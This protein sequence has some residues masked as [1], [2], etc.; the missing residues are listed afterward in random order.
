MPSIISLGYITVDAGSPVS[1]FTNVGG[2][3]ASK[4]VRAVF[5]QTTKG[6][7]KQSWLQTGSEVV[8]SNG[9]TTDKQNGIVLLLPLPTLST[10][11]P[12]ALPSGSPGASHPEFANIDAAE[13][14]IDGEH[15]G[16]LVL[17]SYLP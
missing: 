5:C 13:L 12:L 6:N 7:T 10:A 15:D 8:Q 11:D 1:I 9:L 17:V 16:D 2:P 4:K 3:P 14:Y